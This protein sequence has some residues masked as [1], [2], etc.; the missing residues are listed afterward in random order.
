HGQLSEHR[1]LLTMA[2][3]KGRSGTS[4]ALFPLLVLCSIVASQAFLCRPAGWSQLHVQ[5]SRYCGVAGKGW[6]ENIRNRER[7]RTAT[8]EANQLRASAAAALPAGEPQ[9][10]RAE[11][12]L[13]MLDAAIAIPAASTEEQDG[14][15][16]DSGGGGNELSTPAPEEHREIDGGSGGGVGGG[17]KGRKKPKSIRGVFR[18]ASSKALSYLTIMTTW[19]VF[20]FLLKGLNKV[21]CH[22]RQALLDAVLDRGDRGLLTVSNHM[23]VYDDPG[24]WSALLPF[25]RTG[26]RR[27]RWALCTDDIY[28]AHPVLKNIFQAGRTLPIKRTRGME[29]P[30]FK[31][32]FLFLF[33]SHL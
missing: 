3:W 17:V 6:P 15:S 7:H 25:W 13:G 12:S 14:S 19:V 11:T 27:M 21:E 2:R 31:V 24:L 4:A 1:L 29:Q 33:A 10:Q 18:R 26:R 20:R 28:Y 23:C 22:N 8:E 16:S 5:P 30:L 32:S 9:Q